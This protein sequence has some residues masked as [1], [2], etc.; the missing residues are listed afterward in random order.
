[1]DDWLLNIQLPH[2]PPPPPSVSSSLPLPPPP[3]PYPLCPPPPPTCPPYPNPPPPSLLPPPPP[4]LPSAS[5]P[6]SLPRN[7][8][9]YI[10]PST[11]G[12]ALTVQLQITSS[13]K[14]SNY[15][16]QN[17]DKY[18]SNHNTEQPETPLTD[19]KITDVNHVSITENCASQIDYRASDLASIQ[20]M[21]LE[22]LHLFI[23]KVLGPTVAPENVILFQKALAQV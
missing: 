5:T 21:S 14:V 17:T 22:Q 8:P 11:L 9:S 19:S 13:Q 18:F 15:T 12:A 3:L 23:P 20:E 1:M 7:P 16:M 2:L 6:T 4:P 10:D